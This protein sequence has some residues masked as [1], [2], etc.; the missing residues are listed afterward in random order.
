[1]DRLRH[2]VEYSARLA[3]HVAG[4]SHDQYLASEALQDAVLRCLIVIGEAC[5]HLS[6]PARARVTDV[7]WPRIVGL[8]HFIVHSYERLDVSRAWITATRDVPVLH[9]AIASALSRW[10]TR[11]GLQDNSNVR[12]LLTAAGIG[13]RLKPITDTLPKALVPIASKPLLE[14]W[15]DAFAHAG[16]RH[17]LVNTHHMPELIRAFLAAK[18]ATGQFE[19]SETYEPVLLG[20]AGTISANAAFVPRVARES[21]AG[22]AAASPDKVAS[23][24]DGTDVLIIYSDNLSNVDL[25]AFLAFHRWHGD[26]FTML[27]FRAQFPEKSGIAEVAPDGRVLSFIEKPKQ[28]KSDL[29]NAGMYAMSAAM[30]HEIASWNAFDIGFDVLP[31]IVASGRMRAI[32]HAR[33]ARDGKPYHRDIGTHESLA[34]ATADAPAI[35]GS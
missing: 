23:V 30:W 28:P 24:G 1:M 35:F 17:V 5:A 21:A 31:R 16:I 12:V 4:K 26:P 19:A 27:L 25:D 34:I 20:S 22:G 29:A 11:W 7:A 3:R 32:E 8:R 33:V 2:V 18:N 15:F 6:D 10:P 9:T 13:S 14:Y